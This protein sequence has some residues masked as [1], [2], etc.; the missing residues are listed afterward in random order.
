MLKWEASR[1]ELGWN[2]GIAWRMFA[3]VPKGEVLSGEDVR[4]LFDLRCCTNLI[5]FVDCEPFHTELSRMHWIDDSSVSIEHLEKKNQQEAIQSPNTEFIMFQPDPIKESKPT[6]E[7]L[8][9]ST[10]PFLPL[11]PGIFGRG[12]EGVKPSG[13]FFNF[14]A[15]TAFSSRQGAWTKQRSPTSKPAALE[16]H[17]DDGENNFHDGWIKQNWIHKYY[18]GWIILSRRKKDEEFWKNKR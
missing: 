5:K 13:T 17:R 16:I 9:I 11:F 14:S 1:G 12:T 10:R 8:M 2:L 18:E 3:I 15:S 6:N 4:K 7:R